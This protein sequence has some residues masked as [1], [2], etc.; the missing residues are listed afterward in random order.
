MPSVQL[1][2][3]RKTAVVPTYAH[4]DD[5]GFDLYAADEVEIGAGE[6][7]LIPLG[8]AMGI[9]EGWLVSIRPRSG[10]SLKTGLRVANS[11]GTID[12]GFQNEVNVILHNTSNEKKV[13]MVGDRIAQGIL[14]RVNKASFTFVEQFS[15]SDRGQEGLGSTGK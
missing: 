13:I 11:P 12:S 4:Y 10:M 8:Y 6:T 15:P 1:K 7:K 5:A 14:E 3:L 2:R 9:P